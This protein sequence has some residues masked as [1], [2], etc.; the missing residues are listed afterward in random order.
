M[1]Y[2]DHYHP[3]AVKLS[4]LVL[5]LVVILLFLISFYEWKLGT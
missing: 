2:N 4:F 1:Q 5:A 3:L